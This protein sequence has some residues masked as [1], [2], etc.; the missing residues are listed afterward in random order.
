LLIAAHTFG[1][2]EVHANLGVEFNADDLERTRGRYALGATLQPHDRLAF[3]LDLLGSS[4]FVDDRFTIPAPAGKVFH[5]G[6]NTQLF[7]NDQ[8]VQSIGRTSVTAFVPRSDV[9]DV[10]VG[11]KVNVI[12]T[13]VAFASAIVPLTTDGLRAEVIPAAG[14]EATF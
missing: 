6:P 8:L 14:V 10:A 7:G 12:R 4:S 11:L 3:L 2:H 5:S 9:L 13:V 1:R